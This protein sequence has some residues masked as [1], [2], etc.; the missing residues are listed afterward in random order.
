LSSLSRRIEG[1]AAIDAGVANVNE[2]VEALEL[3]AELG[4]LPDLEMRLQ[5]AEGG[6]TQIATLVENIRSL[7]QALDEPGLNDSLLIL[8]SNSAV[9]AW[10]TALP[11]PAETQGA[12]SD[13]LNNLGQLEVMDVFSKASAVTVTEQASSAFTRV[14][15]LF[16]S[17]SILAGVLLIFTVFVMMA[18]ERKNEMGIAR[19]IGMQ[20]HH[21][22]Q[23]FVSEGAAYDLVAALGGV[24]LGLGASYVMIHLLSD[25]IG[26]VGSMGGII[27]QFHVE[28]GSIIIAYCIG[29]LLTFVVV[30][31][32]S[33]RVSRLN[34]VAAIRDIPES[35]VASAD[36]SPLSR[37]W[38]VGRGPLLALVGVALLSRGGRMLTLLGATLVLVGVS[39]LADWL[40]RRTAVQATRRNRLV[41]SRI[42]VGLLMIGGVPWGV[43]PEGAGGGEGM[44]YSV[45][46]GVLMMAGAILTVMYNADVLSWAAG[47][48]LGGIGALTPVLKTAIAYPLSARFRTGMAMTMFASVITLVTMMSVITEATGT[49]FTLTD[50]VSGGFDI[51]ASLLASNPIADM[52]AEL[53]KHPEIPADDIT[54]IGRGSSQAVELHQ[55]GTEQEWKH[56]QIIGLDQG[57]LEQVSPCLVLR[58]ACAGV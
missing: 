7:P 27:F 15:F 18:T 35:E 56:H 37:A 4:V 55:V 29:V 54:A 31:L 46:A 28:T 11:L 12:L 57:F 24:A 43:L 32:A 17:F 40:L 19:A 5:A 41:Y 9:R 30:T 22:I 44:G 3:E 1:R 53:K 38:Q 2:T 23:M 16:G 45:L 42:G 48:L 52:Q 10:L 6:E 51:I 58:T 34:I 21:L 14:F 36:V 13:G 50:D 25:L 20:R 39:L 47:R 26:N 33:W 49:L 8:L